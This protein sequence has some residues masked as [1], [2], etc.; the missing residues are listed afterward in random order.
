MNMHFFLLR[1]LFSSM[2]YDSS[3]WYNGFHPFLFMG[4]HMDLTAMHLFSPCQFQNEP[5]KHDDQFTVSPAP[6]GAPLGL[7]VMCLGRTPAF[8]HCNKS[9]SRILA[10]LHMKAGIFKGSLKTKYD[11]LWSNTRGYVKNN[12][13][14]DA[15]E[16]VV[17][18]IHD[19]AFNSN[20][21]M[22]I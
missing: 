12:T 6:L 9:Q 20:G 16:K 1:P 5:H 7:G 13:D 15:E 2:N 11:E 3:T 4:L 19:C 10:K 14:L 8:K 18:L 21:Q 22:S 17:F